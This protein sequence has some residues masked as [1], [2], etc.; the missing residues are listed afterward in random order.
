MAW[1]AKY[2]PFGNAV[3]ITNDRPPCPLRFPGQ[4]FQIEDGL[5]ENWHRDDYPTLGR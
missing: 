5:N 3:T 2:D 4:Y 1:A